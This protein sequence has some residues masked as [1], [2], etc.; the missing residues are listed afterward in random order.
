MTTIYW[1]LSNENKPNFHFTEPKMQV[2][3][4]FSVYTN[5]KKLFSCKKNESADVLD[6]LNGIRVLSIVWVVY[7][8]KYMMFI[9]SPSINTAYLAEVT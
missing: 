5:G 9:T 7:G 6:C 2:L 3:I 4:A 1:H 8:H